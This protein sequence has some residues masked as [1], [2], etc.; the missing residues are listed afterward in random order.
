[1]RLITP[2][3]LIATSAATGCA[4]LATGGFDD[5]TDLQRVS[6]ID[7]QARLRGIELHWVNMPQKKPDAVPVAPAVP[8]ATAPSGT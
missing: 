7:R 2:L 8:A 3:A 5:R 6:M 1:M 4:A